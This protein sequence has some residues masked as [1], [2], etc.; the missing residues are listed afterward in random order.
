[1]RK[2]DPK[3]KKQD[4]INKIVEMSCK[5]VLQPEIINWL[6]TEGQCKI[7]YCYDLLRESKSLINDTL[8]ELSKDRLEKTIAD[9]EHMMWEAKKSGD[10]KLQLEIYK[11]IN[12]ITGIGTQKVDITTGG[13]EINSISVIRLIEIK[14]NDDENDKTES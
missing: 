6:M 5:G 14:N 9:L 12:K 8:K 7:A 11:E 13:K 2:K 3:Y 1:M 4:L 10:K